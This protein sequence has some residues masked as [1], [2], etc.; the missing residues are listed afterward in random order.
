MRKLVF[1]FFLL[2]IILSFQFS[3][4]KAI[5][6]ES[7]SEHIG[8]HAEGLMWKMIWSLYQAASLQWE[9]PLLR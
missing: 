8:H 7:A 6:K 3:V 1:S 4:C 9:A 5:G 2:F